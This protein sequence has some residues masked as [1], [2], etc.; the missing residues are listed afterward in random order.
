MLQWHELRVAVET[1]THDG[2]TA[3]WELGR[4]AVL[5]R[6]LL[7][8]EIVDAKARVTVELAPQR[9]VRV[10]ELAQV[11]PVAWPNGVRR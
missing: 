9:E 5:S 11:R 7:H 10:H 1:H 6:D 2:T 8:A 4:A 3:A